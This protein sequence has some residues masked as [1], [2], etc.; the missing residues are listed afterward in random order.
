MDTRSL[1]Y[2][3]TLAETGNMTKAAKRLYISQPTLSQ[4]LS[5][6]EAAVGATLFE[7]VNGKYCLTPTGEL[8]ADYARLVL[9]LTDKLEKDIHKLC[10]AAQIVV[11]TSTSSAFKILVQVLPAFCKAYPQVEL[12]MMDHHIL[13]SINA[14][15]SKGDVDIALASVPSLAPYEGRGVELRQEEIRLVVPRGHPYVQRV[16]CDGTHSVTCA[17]FEQQFSDTPLIQQLSG[18]C[19]RYLLDAFLDGKPHSTVCNTNNAQAICDMVTGN[20][21]IGFVPAD[22]AKEAAGTVSFSLEPKMYRIHALLYRK[23]LELTA[24]I[25]FL[26]SLIQKYFQVQF[27]PD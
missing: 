12:T 1:E 24:P 19:I 22:Y 3:L 9:S 14:A 8:Y 11:G 25:Q 16:P 27:A 17:E 7:R 20:I 21:G 13:R 26:S 10:T 23:N 2:I 5:K 18:S 4:F 15:L 6:Q